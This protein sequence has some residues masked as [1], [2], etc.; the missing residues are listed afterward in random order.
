LAEPLK[1]DILI[2]IYDGQRLGYRLHRRHL[3]G[4]E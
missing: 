3:Q 2:Q 4:V 1:Y